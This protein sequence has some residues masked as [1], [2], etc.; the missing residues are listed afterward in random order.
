MIW[1]KFQKKQTKRNSEVCNMKPVLQI[2]L[3]AETHNN[4]T[5]FTEG[6]NNIKKK[7]NAL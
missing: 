7:R 2:S 1:D 3:A 4:Y 5:E 6:F